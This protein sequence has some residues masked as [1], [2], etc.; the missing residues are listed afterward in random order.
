LQ[1]D[2]YGNALVTHSG[3]EARG[4]MRETFR[5]AK[6]INSA[7]TNYV[8]G[9]P[10]VEKN[11][12]SSTECTE[13]D[14][15][16]ISASRT[17]FDNLPL[18]QT[19]QKNLATKKETYMPTDNG[20]GW[21]ATT[22][23]YDNVG[24]MFDTTDAQGI[25][26]EIAYDDDYRQFPKMTTK[27]QGNTSYQ[28]V[29]TYDARFGKVLSAF[30]ATSGVWA[31]TTLD[32]TGFVTA[33]QTQNGTQILAK[34]NF[35]H[36][37]YNEQPAWSEECT[38][39]GIDFSQKQ[40]TKKFA[41]AL[42]RVYR[43]EYP[44]FVGGVEQRMAVEVRYDSR[45]RD[46]KSS[47]PFPSIHSGCAGTLGAG[48]SSYSC[49]WNTKAY[50]VMNRVVRVDRYNGR[51]STNTYQTIG[52]P[53]GLT[54][55]VTTR[56]E[57]GHVKMTQTNIYGKVDAVYE[58]LDASNTYTAVQ[59]VYDTRA[60]L[61][62]VYAPQGVTQIGYLGFSTQQSY[63][64]DP[65]VGRTDYE[66]Y[67][68]PGNPSFGKMK[69]ETRGDY[70]VSYEYNASFGRL[71]KATRAMASAPSTALETTTYVYD[72][73][74]LPFGKGRLTSLTHVKDGFTIRE[75]YSHDARGQVVETVRRVS[76]ATETLCADAN[77]IPCLQ[78][79]GRTK[80][81]LGR[82]TDMLYPDGKHSTA[83]YADNFS[84]QAKTIKHDGT[85]YAAYSD[86]TYDVAPH[87]GKITYGNG[88][89][90]RFTYEPATGMLDTFKITGS[91]AS[92]LIDL[93]YW[94]DNSYNIQRIDDNVVS[95][96]SVS[97]DYDALNRLKSAT[98]DSGTV[99]T[100]KFDRDGQTNSK[101]N[102]EL[103][104]KRRLT[105][106]TDKTYPAS[107]EVFN[108]DTGQWQQNQTFGWS[109]NG[110]GHLLTLT[111]PIT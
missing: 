78:V 98:L 17:Y 53:D 109:A 60:R 76:H 99:R 73:T 31:T 89:E 29:T 35:A 108:S 7:N 32:G 8:V 110:N 68:T 104:D 111:T 74:D 80:D 38:L 43:T 42:G 91:A 18:G 16:F 39:Y 2:V 19:G 58:G 82:T 107:D 75:R 95:D 26:I 64:V 3:V 46:Y 79:F 33:K 92:P 41:D 67:L 72:E 81:N 10:Y 106:V 96:L 85:T 5:Y 28:T 34:Q 62:Q 100:Y 105:Y 65:N 13:G 83:E 45:G 59:Y 14:A 4:Q 63:I 40:C 24:N 22:Y 66:Y 90:H 69:S 9:L 55:R 27:S 12:F 21:A 102:L 11:C 87:I 37:A 52:L 15:N 86:Y 97:F 84:S 1:Y 94:Y 103:K 25:R 71:S 57:D 56:G 51:Y 77:A 88:L 44:E 47:E 20:G 54:S 30:D 6:Y 36:S 50:D 49:K 48:S 101:G 93:K 70:V 23:T 61:T